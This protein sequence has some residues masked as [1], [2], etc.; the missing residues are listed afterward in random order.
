M[1]RSIYFF[2]PVNSKVEIRGCQFN[3]HSLQSREETPWQPCYFEIVMSGLLIL[4][5]QMVTIVTIL[6]E[7]AGKDL[8]SLL[9]GWTPESFMPLTMGTL[10]DEN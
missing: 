10:K 8:S 5:T 3:A 7:N 1:S 9:F 2:Y 6:K 4:F